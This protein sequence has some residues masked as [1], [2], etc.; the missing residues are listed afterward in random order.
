MN[1]QNRLFAEPLLAGRSPVPYLQAI[2]DSPGWID[3][4]T[5]AAM[6]EQVQ[7]GTVKFAYDPS[8]LVEAAEDAALNALFLTYLNESPLKSPFP[9]PHRVLALVR[10]IKH[11]IETADTPPPV[12]LLDSHTVELA[13][14]TLELWLNTAAAA[15]PAR[16][17]DEQ[18]ALL[19]DEVMLITA[20]EAASLT[21]IGVSSLQQFRLRGQ[22]PQYVKTGRNDTGIRYPVVAL[23]GWLYGYKEENN[24]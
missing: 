4:E 10:A 18:R 21:G 17:T 13:E 23:L 24:G 19:R 22:G 6:A 5:V 11:L 9:L 15:L 3:Y 14:T 16:F 2:A 8:E 12:M 7:Q 1:L 20:K